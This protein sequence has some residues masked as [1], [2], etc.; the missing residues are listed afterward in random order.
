MLEYK[1]IIANFEYTSNNNGIVDIP[2]IEC[3][4][5]SGQLQVGMLAAKRLNICIRPVVDDIIEMDEI[6]FYIR[7]VGTTEWINRGIYFISSRP[8]SGADGKMSIEAFDELYTLNG[9]FEEE[10]IPNYPVS[11]I[12]LINAIGFDIDY[13]SLNNIQPYFWEFTA[14][15]PKF[16]MLKEIASANG[17]NIHL[18]Y[19]N[20]IRICII[21]KEYNTH[22]IGTKAQSYY[23]N[24]QQ[25]PISR[26][27]LIGA[28]ET[29]MSVGDN[30]NILTI[31]VSNATQIMCDNLF[32]QLNGYIYKPFTAEKVY[33]DFNFN[34]G[35]I[36]EI[37]G[38]YHVIY[39]YLTYF[40]TGSAITASNLSAPL[41]V[42]GGATGAISRGA[43]GTKQTE[44]VKLPEL[45]YTF[46]IEP[47]TIGL[48]EF[49]IAELV[50]EVFETT[51]ARSS[52]RFN[53]ISSTE[54]EVCIRL[55]D[56]ELQLLDSPYY[57]IA[58][59]GANSVGF[60]DSFINT[61]PDIHLFSVTMQC[62]TGWCSI[63]AR[64]LK[65]S[66]DLYSTEVYFM[67]DDVRDLTLYQPE[68]SENP[69]Y[70]YSAIINEFNNVAILRARYD[71]GRRYLSKD[72]TLVWNLDDI[73]NVKSLAIEYDGVFKFLGKTERLSLI[74]NNINPQI[75]YI[76]ENDDL[77]EQQG[78]D[79]LSRV[80]LATQALQVSACRGWVGTE[81]T[82]I[83][84]GLC[85]AY[86]KYNGVVAYRAKI[87]GIWSSEEILDEALINNS[88][89]HV[90]RTNDYRM[91][92]TVTGINKSFFTER[93]YITGSVKPEHIDFD[94]I[95]RTPAVGMIPVDDMPILPILYSFTFSSDLTTIYI[96]ANYPLKLRTEFKYAFTVIS[97]TTGANVISAVNDNNKIII[98]LSKSAIL[99]SQITLLP[100][101]GNVV[102][103]YNNGSEV[104]VERENWVI[105]FYITQTG[106]NTELFEFSFLPEPTVWESLPIETDT[107][108]NTELFE[109]SFLPEPTV[110]E[111]LPIET[112]TGY[113]TELFEFSFL[114]EP[115]VWETIFIGIIPI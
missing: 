2:T 85:V 49:R 61:T 88:Y 20:K 95:Q 78:N 59:Q 109:F 56:N 92:F 36:V 28:D 14:D 93:F 35:D 111:S 80:K 32:N 52:L 77:Y 105:N 73:V 44:K 27:E 81:H 70:I 33:I 96:S 11:T 99:P 60:P 34:I 62:T 103:I 71:K 8:T 65:F 106:Y 57:F 66:V 29:F 69:V 9:A 12:D 25:T 98:K 50:V 22:N 21:N 40:S 18:T 30:S 1:A 43:S 79:K 45:I 46:N 48:T 63:G 17:G 89:V 5:M 113:N 19:D 39:N 108:Y 24:K 42:G 47:I 84:A 82:D 83:D 37:N 68:N 26:I 115:T 10:N 112:D 3:N 72:F 13:E 86:I 101:S 64:E 15:K 102:W 53:F 94:F 76:D 97:N 16:E 91:C 55:Y 107:G 74:A 7:E 75:F 114:P 104:P 100:D 110:W 87:K 67:T 23:D 38:N 4:T 58:K 54:Q 90:S 41:E 6:D 51:N 31:E